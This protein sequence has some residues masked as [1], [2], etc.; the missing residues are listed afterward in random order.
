MF[1]QFPESDFC[2]CGK[3]LYECGCGQCGV[4]RDCNRRVHGSIF[5]KHAWAHTVDK[6]ETYRPYVPPVKTSLRLQEIRPKPG[7]KDPN[8]LPGQLSL[9]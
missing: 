2:G 6:G 5:D 7:A 3:P 8:V 4:C 9:F 1:D